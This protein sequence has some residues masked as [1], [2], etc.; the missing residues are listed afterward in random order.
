MLRTSVSFSTYEH[1]K[2][3]LRQLLTLLLLPRC[4]WCA[5]VELPQLHPHSQCHVA[6]WLLLLLLLVAVLH[7]HT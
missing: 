5:A 6:L 2:L 1:Q 3:L 4:C 7:P